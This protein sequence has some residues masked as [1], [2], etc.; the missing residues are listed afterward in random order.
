MEDILEF[1]EQHGVVRSSSSNAW[2]DW[3]SYDSSKALLGGLFNL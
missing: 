3:T 1:L 2:L